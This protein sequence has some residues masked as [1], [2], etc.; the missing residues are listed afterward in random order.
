MGEMRSTIE[1]RYRAIGGGEETT[2][3]A[4]NDESSCQRN[5]DELDPAIPWEC[6]VFSVK[7]AFYKAWFPLTRRWLDFL[8][9]QVHLDPS[10]GRFQATLRVDEPRFSSPGPIEGSFCIDGPRVLGAIVLPPH[11]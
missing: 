2:T 1:P 5:L 7:E 9:V 3:L 4:S 6:V 10:R 11:V 8:D